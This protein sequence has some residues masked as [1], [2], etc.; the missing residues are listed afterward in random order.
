MGANVLEKAAEKKYRVV[1]QSV[2]RRDGMG[3]VTGATKFVGDVHYPGM[4]HLKMVR[5]QN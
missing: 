4:L 1:G 2:P 3:H 5:S